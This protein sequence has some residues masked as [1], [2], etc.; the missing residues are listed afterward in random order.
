MSFGKNFDW[1]ICLLASIDM[2]PSIDL[3]VALEMQWGIQIFA[4]ENMFT[5]HR[6]QNA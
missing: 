5:Y 1:Q 6:F 2:K 4:L 3:K